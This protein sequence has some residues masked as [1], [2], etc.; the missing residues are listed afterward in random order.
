MQTNLVERDRPIWNKYDY[1]LIDIN[2]A[3]WEPITYAAVNNREVFVE[4]FGS[5]VENGLYFT[6]QNG[7]PDGQSRAYNLSIQR[8]PLGINSTQGLVITELVDGTEVPYTT[9]D[10]AIN[11]SGVVS[12]YRTQVLK[13]SYNSAPPIN[14]PPVLAPIGNKTVDEGK[15]LSFNVS[16]TDPENNQIIFNVF[17]LPS[18]ATF[19]DHRDGT[20][21][22]TWTPNYYQADDY[23]VTFTADDGHG[24][25]DSETINI[26]VN[27]VDIEPPILSNIRTSNLTYNSATISWTT[28]EPATSKVEY[29]LTTS[30]GRAVEDSSLVINHSLSLS[31]LQYLTTYHY[32]VRSRDAVGN[33]AVSSDYTFTTLAPPISCQLTPSANY[34]YRGGSIT[35]SANVYNNSNLTLTLDAWI[36]DKRPDNSQHPNNPIAGPTRMTL[37]PGTTKTITFVV[38]VPVSEQIGRHTQTLKV[39]QRSPLTLYASSETTVEIRQ[40]TPN[41]ADNKK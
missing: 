20:G 3:G 27:N 18:G 32:R 39:G 16:A 31:N 25:I 30:Y 21:T 13:L 37:A 29:G 19:V 38:N 12:A 40:K 34:V 23:M 17:D 41:P 4:R 2:K 6:A 15:T 9:S 8:G 28:N 36:D 33:E 22:F 5:S 35:S 26:K 14:Q 24:G 7:K 11:L 10:A 1:L